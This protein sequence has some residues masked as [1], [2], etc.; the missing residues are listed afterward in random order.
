MLDEIYLR[1]FLEVIPDNLQVSR[2]DIAR[3][4]DSSETKGSGRSYYGS[5][6]KSVYQSLPESDI[7]LS[8]GKFLY[9]STLCDFSRML[10]TA[11]NLQAAFELVAK[12]HYIH[13]A[14]FFPVISR[15]PG[16]VSIA[17]TYPYRKNASEYQRRFCAESVF[18]YI[19]NSIRETIDPAYCPIAIT[20]D[21]PEVPYHD[22]CRQQFGA[23]VQFVQPLASIEI[24]EKLLYVQLSTR[25]PTL[26][27][28]YINKCLDSWK[29]SESRQNFEYRAITY[30]MQY[31]PETF[32]SQKLASRL[33]ISIR[34]LQ[35]RF[36]KQ[37]DS[38]SQLASLARRELVKVYLFQKEQGIDFTAEQLGFQSNSGF[39]RFFKA[40]FD[41]SPGEYLAQFDV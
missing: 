15:K 25:N 13:G 41:L 7:G 31:H 36:S 11:D 37:G 3:I 19:L 14:G 16:K 18:S 27:Q 10:M 23:N 4:R 29:E 20:L 40:E 8:F 17:L 24:D 21:Y 32:N 30:L 38:F 6:I 12:M 9:P 39:R 22:K 26:H 35:K 33:N 5:L 28:L 34:G 1:L 2:L